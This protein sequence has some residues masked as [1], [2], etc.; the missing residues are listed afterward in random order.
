[1][2]EC[3]QLQNGASEGHRV[4]GTASHGNLCSASEKSSG[5]RKSN[6][7]AA[8]PWKVLAGTGVEATA[9]GDR[10]ALAGGWGNGKELHGFRCVGTSESRRVGHLGHTYAFEKDAEKLEGGEL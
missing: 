4:Q 8:G 1:M 10:P 2:A 5:G 6:I 7:G 3:K 9:G